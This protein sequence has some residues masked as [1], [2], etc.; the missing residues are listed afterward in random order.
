MEQLMNKRQEYLKTF[1]KA[2]LIAAFVFL[3]MHQP[4]SAQTQPELQTALVKM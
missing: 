3:C 4:A 1:I 2:N